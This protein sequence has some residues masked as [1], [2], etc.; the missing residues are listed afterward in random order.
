MVPASRLGLDRRGREGDARAEGQTRDD[1]DG[2]GATHW[3]PRSVSQRGA[4]AGADV[5][6]WAAT[7]GAVVSSWWME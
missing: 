5:E 7:G 4:A 2:G 3:G 6:G 1:G